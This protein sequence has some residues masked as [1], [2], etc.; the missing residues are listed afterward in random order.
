MFNFDFLEKRL[1]IVSPPHLVYDFSRKMFFMLDSMNWPN[2]IAWLPIFLEILVNM[3]IAI[4]RLPGFD[5]ISY[6][7][8]RIFLIKSFFYMTKKSRQ[9][10]KCLENEKQF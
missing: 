2:F 1:G 4:V 7:I 10:F 6:E 3:C 9:K 8:N 5:I